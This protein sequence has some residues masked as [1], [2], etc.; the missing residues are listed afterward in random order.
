MVIV[1]ALK[2][3]TRGNIYRDDTL[4]VFAENMRETFAASH[5]FSIKVIGVFQILMFDIVTK[6][7]LT[8]LLFLDN[9]PQKV[10]SFPADVRRIWYI[11]SPKK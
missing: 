10:T 4:I 7:Q 5:I 2:H 9:R 6:C 3:I 11:R 8:T 1:W